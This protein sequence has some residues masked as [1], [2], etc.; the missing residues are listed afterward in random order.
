MV[1]GSDG[2]KSGTIN[3]SPST[4]NPRDSALSGGDSGGETPVPIPNTEVKAACADGTAASQR[5]KS[6][7]PPD[8]LQSAP[9]F[10]LGAHRL[11]LNDRGDRSTG[12]ERL[13][14]R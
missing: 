6:R 5:W 8:Y 7:S 3:H 10:M 2:P 4:I 9:G 12:R 13:P 1:D 14:R 11:Y